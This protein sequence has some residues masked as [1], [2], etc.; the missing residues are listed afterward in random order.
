MCKHASVAIAK[1]SAMPFPGAQPR[2]KL[3]CK[4]VMGVAKWDV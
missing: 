1:L 2:V 4:P 3:V